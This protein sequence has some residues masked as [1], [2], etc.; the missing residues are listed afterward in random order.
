MRTARAPTAKTSAGAFTG[1]EDF[2]R[3]L[4]SR[5]QSAQIRAAL[6][7]NS[8][9]T[10]LYWHIRREILARQTARGWGAKVI[11]QLAKDLKSAFPEMKGFSP[12]NLKYMLLF[13]ETYGD[14]QFV[15]QVA[16]QIPWFH[17]CVLLDKVK[18]S[19]ARDW[20]IRQTVE[21]GWS[22]N[23]LTLQ[24]E[25]N[26]HGRQGKAVTNFA[27]TLPAPPLELHYHFA[28]TNGALC[29]GEPFKPLA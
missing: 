14:E 28:G 23:I 8:E 24:I 17:N 26:L 27:E 1:Y 18:D 6:S 3:D 5:I 19:T 25:T 7:V 12:R 11:D 21:N 20:Y 15:Q 9:L 4:K 13:A 2:L 29:A 16:A 10:A 22:R